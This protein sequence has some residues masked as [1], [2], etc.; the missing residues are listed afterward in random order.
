M[1]HVWPTF[2]LRKNKSE[3][4]SRKMQTIEAKIETLIAPVL[5]DMGVDLVELALKGVMGN[6]IIQIYLD[7][8]TGSI[9]VGQCQS[10]SRQVAAIFEAEDFI[11]GKYRLEVS[12]PGVERPMTS[13]RDFQ[14]NIG[15]QA[16]VK[17]WLGEEKK[18][19]QGKL[20]AV[21]EDA[22]QI[23]AGKQKTIIPLETIRKAK[24]V[25]K[26]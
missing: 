17:Y 7:V 13:V 6:R 3:W 18:T 2:L 4:A 12:S 23:S 5:A 15:R 21:D 24:I 25:L 1:G 9:S 11:D 22:I 26:W 10:V 19:L 20:E 8:P 16:L 14:K